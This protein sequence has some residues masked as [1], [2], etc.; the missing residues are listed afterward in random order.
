MPNMS[1]GSAFTIVILANYV[2]NKSSIEFT[3]RELTVLNNGLGY[4]VSATTRLDETIVNIEAGIKWLSNEAKE[5][6]RSGIS[7]ISLNTEKKK[8]NEHQD[9]LKMVRQL[10]DKPVY[11]LKADKGNNVVIMA[12]T[13][14]DDAVS[15]K[16]RNGNFFELRKDPMPESIKRVDRALKEASTLFKDITKLR[17]P[18]PSLPRIRCQPKI[19]KEGHE[20]REIIAGSNSPT[21]KIAK[22]L[23]HEFLAL[24]N[25]LS[26]YAIRNT[27]ELTSKLQ[28]AGHINT[29]EMM[30]SFDVK[31]L[32]PNTAIKPA[33]H[34]LEVWL[35]KLNT[36]IDWRAKVR[37]YTKLA[38]L[39]MGENYFTF[40]DK[41]YKTTAGVSMGNPMSPL[42]TAMFMAY[43]ETII[44][45]KGIMPRIWFRYVD[46]IFAIVEKDRVDNTLTEI[47][48]IHPK[49]QFTIEKEEHGSLPFLDLREINNSGKLEFE[50]YRK[51]TATQRTTPATSAHTATQKTA[52]YNSM[53]AFSDECRLEAVTEKLQYVRRRPSERYQ[54][55]C[56]VRTI[57]HPPAA[58]IWSLISADGP[59][60]LYFVEGM[61]AC[62]YQTTFCALI[63]ITCDA[64]DIQQP[65]CK[66][67]HLV[68]VLNLQ[69]IC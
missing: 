24:G 42:V 33:I 67:V 14:Y 11:Y 13:D 19:H 12:K 3:P 22:W 26:K 68:I 59:G 54:E 65:L 58:M 5:E 52:A 23:V 64:A 39:C 48:R 38:S 29:N 25:T 50:I 45:E 27:G 60:P 47:N 36:T 56:V 17:M 41:F 9:D 51:P 16:L 8:L 4:A 6:I 18:N 35:N 61:D 40:R 49:I 2:V 31:S 43:V 20:M 34:Q 32:F 30:V 21:F 55:D 69:L 10:R 46:D 28:E 57:K 63:L 7:K 44:E 62:Q 37:Q 1:T 66:M 15:L 53:V